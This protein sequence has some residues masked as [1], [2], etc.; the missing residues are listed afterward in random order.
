MLALYYPVGPPDRAIKV[1]IVAVYTSGGVM[2]FFKGGKNKL[3]S[4]WIHPWER[5][6]H[7]MLIS[8]PAPDTFFLT[9]DLFSFMR[10]ESPFQR[11]IKFQ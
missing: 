2:G 1:A 7:V 4:C 3:L 9:Y 11:N 8:L 10:G 6:E 5:R